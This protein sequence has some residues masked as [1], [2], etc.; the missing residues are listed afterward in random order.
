MREPL[1][2]KD[3]YFCKQTKVPPTHTTKNS[4][5][6][7]ASGGHQ[8]PSILFVWVEEVTLELELISTSKLIPKYCYN[9]QNYIYIYNFGI[10]K[11]DE[12]DN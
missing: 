8:Q 10:I 12:C 5:V 3:A 1:K 11:E 7:Y 6:T 9:I 2:K 4:Y